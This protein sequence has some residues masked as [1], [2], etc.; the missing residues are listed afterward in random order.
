MRGKH[1][2]K[3]LLMPPSRLDGNLKEGHHPLTKINP[4][5]IK[6]SSSPVPHRAGQLLAPDQPFP[7]VVEHANRPQA[8]HLRHSDRQF[9][10]PG[11]DFL[12]QA[13]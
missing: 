7:M 4:H 9:P 11:I 5:P 3:I 2:N 8:M 13:F 10:A 1:S 12:V 6:K